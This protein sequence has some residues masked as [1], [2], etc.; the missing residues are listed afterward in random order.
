M[1][2]VPLPFVVALLLLLL[3]ADLLRSRNEARPNAPFLALLVG[4]AVQSTLAGLRWTYG[5]EA[6]SFVQPVLAAM[7]PALLAASFG[8]LARAGRGWRPVW[9]HALPATFVAALLVI[10]PYVVDG[11]LIVIDLAYAA[12]LLWLARSGPDGLRRAP[13]EGVLPTWRALQAAA[14]V[15][16]ASAAVD[17]LVVLTLEQGDARRA[18]TIIGLANLA[19]LCV[20]GVAASV[21]GRVRPPADAGD[22]GA[23]EPAAESEDWPV[24]VEAID[25]LVGDGQLFRDASLNLSRLARRAGLPA[26]RVSMAVNRV[27][28][29]NVSQYINGYRIREACQ[30]LRET[31]QPVTSILFDVGFQTKSNFNREFRRV[32]GM[33]PAAWRQKENKP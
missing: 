18:A 4:C 23:H 20:L 1:P 28:R 6:V 22:D 26:R 2:V 27:H 11:T 7:L 5:I 17:G 13:F 31:D 32:T 3:L 24:I 10:R 9:I 33:S 19:G 21:A 16:V 15:L 30:L 29:Q 12:R 8:G 14:F 25:R